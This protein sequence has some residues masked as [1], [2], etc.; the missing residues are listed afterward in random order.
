M[1]LTIEA[2]AFPI[3]GVFRIARGAKTEAHVLW[4]KL[5]ENGFVGV[6][7]SV[8]YARYNETIEASIAGIEAMRPQIEAGL[9]FD[10]LLGLLPAGAARN[11]VDCALWDLRAKQ[12]SKTVADTLGLS[13]LS[14]LT[15]AY[16]ISLDSAD[17][18]AAQAAKNAHRPLLKLKIGGPDDLSRIEAVHK[19][20]PKAALIVDG[21]EGLRFDDFKALCPELKK[22]GVT[23][24]E[25][26]LK[27]G[28]DEAL[29][30]FSSDVPLCADESLHTREQL[31]RIARLYSHINI[32]LDKS[33]GLTEALKLKAE[34]ETLGLKIMVGCMVA[35]SLSMAPAFLLAQGAAFVDLDGPLLLAKDRDPALRVEGSLLYPPSPALWG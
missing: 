11:A 24:I 31:S 3:A 15:T 7:E 27:S 21:N 18:M 12:S 14:P 6:G 17:A 2:Q 30:G 28:E 19:A 5:E 1:K 16:T 26:P 33:G 29:L 9:D 23:L 34:A 4:V 13:P 8:P 20:A 25:Q 35:T 10:T 32:K 22:L